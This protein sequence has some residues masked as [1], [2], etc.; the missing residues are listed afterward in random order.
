VT[1]RIDRAVSVIRLAK[2]FWSVRAWQGSQRR[3]GM[4]Q[5]SSKAQGSIVSSCL[6]EYFGTRMH[7]RANCATLGGLQ[8]RGGTDTTGRGGS[9]SRVGTLGAGTE[10]TCMGVTSSRL[11]WLQDTRKPCWWKHSQQPSAAAELQ[12]VSMLCVGTGESCMT[13]R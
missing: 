2:V 4:L 7:G 11:V 8:G 5:D 9:S 10:D 12:I 6:P 1:T 13:G 3:I